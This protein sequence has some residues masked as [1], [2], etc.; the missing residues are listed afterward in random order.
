M[1][2]IIKFSGNA[3]QVCASLYALRAMFGKGAT[4][5]EVAT[6]THRARIETAVRVQFNGER[7]TK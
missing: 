7:G 3:Q 5:E 2:N 6:A 4:L 1:E